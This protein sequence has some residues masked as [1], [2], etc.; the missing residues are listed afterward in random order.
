VRFT[1]VG[2]KGVVEVVLKPDRREELVPAI[3]LTTEGKPIRQN[4]RAKKEPGRAFECHAVDSVTG[5]PVADVVI[6]TEVRLIRDETGNSSYRRIET[7][8]TKTGSE[9]QFIITIPQKIFQ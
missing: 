7:Y 1:E 6:K 9:G 2:Q 4:D 3:L 5:K 8:T